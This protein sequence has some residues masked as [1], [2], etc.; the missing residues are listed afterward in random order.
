MLISSS[1]DIDDSLIE[2]VMFYDTAPDILTVTPSPAELIV[3]L[4]STAKLEPETYPHP[5]PNTTPS[6][7]FQHEQGGFAQ[8]S[9]RPGERQGR[10]SLSA[11]TIFRH[12]TGGEERE[13]HHT[14]AEIGN[15]S[16]K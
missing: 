7:R 5:P 12:K 6:G 8:L 9:S 4:I 3:L 1:S 14:G 13:P 11:P 10:A 15:S 2:D 16:I